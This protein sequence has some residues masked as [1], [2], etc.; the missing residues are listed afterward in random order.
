MIGIG[1]VYAAQWTPLSI[2]VA[3]FG[4][5]ISGFGLSFI[6]PVIASSGG[7]IP[8]IRPS[9]AISYIAA[10]TYLGYLLGPPFFGTVA[11]LLHGVQWGYLFIIGFI[12]LMVLIPGNPPVNKY[13]AIHRHKQ[14]S[15]EIINPEEES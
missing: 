15:Y 9:D 12:L 5:L 11:D 14:P 8:S 6:G 2:Y 4:L 10:V 1:F 7:D 13:V 3:S